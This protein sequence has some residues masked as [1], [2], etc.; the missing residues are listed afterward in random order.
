MTVVL[1]TIGILGIIMSGMAVGVMLGNSPL[2]GSCGG[3]GG[4]DCVC[5]A[6]EQKRCE[7]REKLLSGA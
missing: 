1:L 4:P 6:F 5:D 7:K 3:E 2:K